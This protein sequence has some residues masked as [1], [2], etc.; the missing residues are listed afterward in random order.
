MSKRGRRHTRRP[1]LAEQSREIRRGGGATSR[2]FHQ[3]QGS[4]ER[5]ESGLEPLL[6]LVWAISKVPGTSRFFHEAHRPFPCRDAVERPGYGTSR[7]REKTFRAVDRN[8]WR[9]KSRRGS[10]TGI[11]RAGRSRRGP[12]TGISA[13]EKVV[14][15]RGQESPRR[16]KLS[17]NVDESLRRRAKSSRAGDGN[18]R[19]GKSCRGPGTGIHRAGRSCRGPWTGF[20][21]LVLRPPLR[22]LALEWRGPQ[23]L[24]GPC[25]LSTSSSAT[26]TAI[27]PPSRRSAP[28]RRPL[29]RRSGSDYRDA[30]DPALRA[31]HDQPR[32]ARRR[33]R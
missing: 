18:F 21:A 31:S 17:G 10:W 22:T 7:R 23:S 28:G 33:H 12:W 20:T 11:R 13:P 25:R 27:S 1:P 16:E 30:D 6:A 8:S 2:S 3:G 14:A 32:V 15:D 19:G 5:V 9:G 24:E 4:P 26:T 29:A